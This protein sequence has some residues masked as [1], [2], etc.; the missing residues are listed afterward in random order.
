MWAREHNR[1]ANTIY[2]SECTSDQ[3]FHLA[4]HIVVSEIQKITYEDY[5]PKLLGTDLKLDQ[6]KYNDYVIPNIP[7]G[8]AA[9]AYRFGHSQVQPTFLR[10]DKNNENITIG[11][12]DLVDA[13][14]DISKFQ[15]TGTDPILRGLLQQKARKVDEFIND[16]L[17]NKLF[18]DDKDSTGFDLASLNI[19][20]GRDHGLSPYFVWKNWATTTCG[21]SSDFMNKDKTVVAMTKVYGSLESVDLFIGGLA[22]NPLPGGIVGATFA[23][24]FL[25]TFGPLRSGDRLFYENPDITTQD[26][27]NDIKRSSLS[28][29][30]C[31]NTKADFGKVP[32]DAFMWVEHNEKVPCTEIDGMELNNDV[33]DCR[34]VGDDVSSITNS[35]SDDELFSLLQSIIKQLGDRKAEGMISSDGEIDNTNSDSKNNILSDEELLEKLEE[36][37]KKK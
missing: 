31:D 15:E 34:D 24:I 25:Q 2:R 8:F 5:L 35:N 33:W 27:M 32:P 23:C 10:L 12:L 9:A 18:A 21:V 17:T 13:F 26:Q 36:L 6:Y 7:N 22:E 4:R 16:V 1:V 19:M 30:I 28:R 14:F 29:V 11:H 3:V 20:R 37:T